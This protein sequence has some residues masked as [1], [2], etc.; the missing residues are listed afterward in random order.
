MKQLSDFTWV[1]DANDSE[2]SYP[3]QD[4][5]NYLMPYI[6]DMSKCRTFKYDRVL[7]ML[8]NRDPAPNVNEEKLN[9]RPTETK[10]FK[11]IFD[12][13]SGNNNA[14]RIAM[15]ENPTVQ[16]LEEFALSSPFYSLLYPIKKYLY[17]H[18]NLSR[19][20]FGYLPMG[21][22]VVK[23]F[24]KLIDEGYIQENFRIKGSAGRKHQVIIQ[25]I[26]NNLARV[27]G[28]STV[29]VNDEMCKIGTTL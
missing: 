5:S 19:E 17:H 23:F 26:T 20:Y 4:V 14:H 27:W 12:T 7:E 18:S 9:I 29:A 25:R 2:E 8:E 10:V 11:R 13:I 1:F 3:F 16:D 28:M 21:S 15:K 24:N 22:P 6:A